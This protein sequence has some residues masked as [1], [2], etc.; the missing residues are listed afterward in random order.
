MSYDTG[1]LSDINT[2]R[3]I[4]AGTEVS[5]KMT[6]PAKVAN[7]KQ[8]GTGSPKIELLFKV[9]G[10]PYA[11]FIIREQLWINTVPKE[12]KEKPPWVTQ[13]LPTIAKMYKAYVN[14]PKPTYGPNGEESPESKALRA[15]ALSKMDQLLAG[16]KSP[17]VVAQRLST[18]VGKSI[19]IKVGA[20]T[21]KDKLKNTISEYIAA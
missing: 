4:P 15:P 7:T 13:A 21:Y 14:V 8:D 6:E 9:E 18:F 12:G 10:G 2:E 16:A 5:V 1:K 20:E 3:T 17:E 11:N 19:K